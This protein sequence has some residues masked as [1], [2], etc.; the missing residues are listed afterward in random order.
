MFI[1]IDIQIDR[2][3]QIGVHR[4]LAYKHAFPIRRYILVSSEFTQYLDLDFQ[5]QFSNKGSGCCREMVDIRACQRKCKISLHHCI[6]P[7]NKEVLLKMGE[8]KGS[9]DGVRSKRQRSLP[10][11]LMLEP[12]EQ[13]KSQYCWIIT[14]PSPQIYGSALL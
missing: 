10:E 14:Q 5:T 12:Y 9:R 2:E 1:L 7:E 8:I 4:Q 3:I 13:N 6:I 11:W